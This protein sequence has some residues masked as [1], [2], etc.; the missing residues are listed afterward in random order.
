MA[1]TKYVVVSIIFNILVFYVQAQHALPGYRVP[2]TTDAFVLPKDTLSFS[3]LRLSHHHLFYSTDSLAVANTTSAY[4]FRLDFQH[5]LPN[6][7]GIDTIFLL[8]GRLDK[9]ELFY[10]DSS[11]QSLSFDYTQRGNLYQESGLSALTIP[12]RVDKLLEG[13]YLFLK[14]FF[15]RASPRLQG[16]TFRYNTPAA[17]YVHQNFVYAASVKDQIPAFILLGIASLLLVFNILL[18]FLG[19]ERQYLY[20]GAFLIFQIAYYSR[21]SYILSNYLFQGNYFLGFLTTEAAQVAANLSY[22]LFVKHFLETRTN[23]PALNTLINIVAVGLMLFIA[24]D[25]IL[26][27]DNPFFTYQTHLMYGHRYFMAAFA[28]LG[29]LYLFIQARGRLR[30]F[31]IAGTICYTGGALSTMFFGE[32]NYMITGSALENIIFALGLS[33]KIRSMNRE[34]LRIEQEANQVRLSALRA[35][36]NPHFIFNSLNSIQHLISKNDKVSALNYL[37]KFSTLLR[38]ILE[39]SIHANIPIKHEI[40]LLTIYLQLESLRFDHAF[41]Y[42]IDVD[43]KLDVH[44]LEV[45]ILVLQPYVENAINHGL[46]PKTDGPKELTISFADQNGYILCLISDTG[47]GREAALARKKT[48][49]INRPSRGLYLSRQRIELLNQDIKHDDLITIEDSPHGT[50]VKIKIPKN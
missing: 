20:Y 23:L 2:V 47:I 46:L 34:K 50:T 6:L 41:Q 29:V 44:N 10:N 14:I 30:Y 48:M 31:I 28:A 36:M 37:T 49:K 24:T 42:K 43:E 39:N 45:P 8:T 22:L 5:A 38:Q 7:T 16:L 19:K 21:G 26:L 13:R 18:Y 9:A 1:K 35:Q 33:Y 32:L 17:E 12:I 40:E 27:I 3:A 4:W 11:M 15:T 25:L